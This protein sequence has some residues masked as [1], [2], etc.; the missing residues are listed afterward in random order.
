MSA[1]KILVTAAALALL[2][3]VPA[4]AQ[5]QQAG[6]PAA[7]AAP[8]LPYGPPISYETAKKMM[9]AAEAEAMKNNWFDAIAIIDPGGH[10]VM[11]HRM[12]NSQT[13]SVHVAQ[14]KARTAVEFRRPSKA[15][16]D[17]IASGGAGVRV[18]SFGVTASEGGSTRSNSRAPGRDP[19]GGSGTVGKRGRWSRA[20]FWL[21]H[22]SQRENPPA[23]S[24]R[25]R[26]PCHAGGIDRPAL[27]R[28]RPRRRGCGAFGSIW[29]NGLQTCWTGA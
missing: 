1:S 20:H 19:V 6:A 8:P 10:L 5:Q 25:P 23:S 7:A 11:L 21:S 17:A 13:G 22:S 29:I 26:K 16:E 28:L 9:A 24:G 15:W 27:S 4:F 14:G 2:A 3:A 12:E 18:L